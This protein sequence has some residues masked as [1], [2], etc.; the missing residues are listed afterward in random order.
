MS[1]PGQTVDEPGESALW[2]LVRIAG[3]KPTNNA[4]ERAL[5]LAVLW[6]RRSFGCPN[7]GGCRFVERMLTVGQTLRLQERRVI[8]YLA[9]AITA[10]RQGLPPPKLLPAS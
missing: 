10:R 3:V 1:D 6:Q 2:A 5:R 8:D 9:D 4:A 7:D